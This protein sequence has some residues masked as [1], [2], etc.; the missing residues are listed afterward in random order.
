MYNMIKHNRSDNQSANT[1][2]GVGAKLR[3]YRQMLPMMAELHPNPCGT[4]AR[5]FLFFRMGWGSCVNQSP[6][7]SSNVHSSGLSSRDPFAWLSRQAPIAVYGVDPQGRVTVW[8]PPAE[9]IFGWLE[10]EVIGREVPFVPDDEREQ[11]RQLVHHVRRHGSVNGRLVKRQTKSGQTIDVVVWAYAQ[12]DEAGQYQGVLAFATEDF[13]TTELSAQLEQAKTTIERILDTVDVCL[14]AH[15]IQNHRVVYGSKGGE[16]IYG[17]TH[18]EFRQNPMLWLEVV[19]PDDTELAY[20]PLNG[21]GPIRTEYRIIRKDGEVRWVANSLYPRYDDCG[22]PV[23]VEGLTIDITERKEHQR[24]LFKMAYTDLLTGLPNRQRFE[25]DLADSVTKAL[26]GQ[27]KLAVML[28]DFDGFKNVNDTFGHHFGDETLKAIAARLREATADGATVYRMGGD[29]FTIVIDPVT[30]ECDVREQAERCL[31]RFQEPLCVGG[32][33]LTI[34]CSIG[35]A[36]CPDHS[37]DVDT[38]QRYADMAM[39]SAKEHGGQ[40]Y[41]IHLAQRQT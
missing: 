27:T 16:K 12:Y 19:H 26:E 10:D 24:E 36:I 37:S 13:R 15:D 40:Q 6:R 21:P 14:F 25:L 11:A 32:E 17:Y 5:D 35:A 20:V 8:S 29:E 3:V 30:G 38:L 41:R 23:F 18:E 31:A 22:R 39:Y 28:L 1:S 34:G 2:K 33:L 7:R 9:R 4:V